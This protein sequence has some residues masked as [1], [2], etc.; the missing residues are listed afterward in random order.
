MCVLPVWAFMCNSD[1][2]NTVL[3]VVCMKCSVRVKKLSLSV[4]VL[5]YTK[6]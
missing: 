2:G 6:L 3:V 5:H 1:S 4:Q